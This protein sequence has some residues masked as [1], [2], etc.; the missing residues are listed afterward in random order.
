[1]GDLIAQWV[2]GGIGTFWWRAG[3]NLALSI[4]PLQPLPVGLQDAPA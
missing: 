1:M 3:R 2:E 4:G